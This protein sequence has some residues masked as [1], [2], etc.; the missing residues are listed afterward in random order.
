MAERTRFKRHASAVIESALAAARLADRAF[1]MTPGERFMRR[2]FYCA[3]SVIGIF[4]L[5]D[6]IKMLAGGP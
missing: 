1:W 6:L 2:A 3:I 5:Y 4:A